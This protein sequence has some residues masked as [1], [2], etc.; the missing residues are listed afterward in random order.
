MAD[1]IS[2]SVRMGYFHVLMGPVRTVH[3]QLSKI[4]PFSLN[5]ADH[6]S[7]PVCM[8]RFFM[9]LWTS[10]ES[11]LSIQAVRMA[12]RIIIS[13]RMGY[14]SCTDGTIPDSPW[15]VELNPSIHYV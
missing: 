10:L 1:G 3:G 2:L 9:A 13:I 7:L 5:K 14:F 4:L 6:I 12:N 15:S 11:P 8:G